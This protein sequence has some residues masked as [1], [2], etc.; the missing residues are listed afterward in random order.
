VVVL[1]GVVALKGVVVLKGVVALKGVVVLKGVV[2]LKGVVVFRKATWR[3]AGGN[4]LPD[5]WQRSFTRREGSS[6][7]SIAVYG[8]LQCEE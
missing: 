2:A 6:P 1:K 8:R 5:E 3:I 4:R 7:A